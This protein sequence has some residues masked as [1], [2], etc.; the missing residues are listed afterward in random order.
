MTENVGSSPRAWGTHQFSSTTPTYFRF[1]PTCMG[2]SS[3][4]RGPFA[5]DTVHPHVH[6]ELCRRDSVREKGAG[7][8]PRAWGTLDNCRAPPC[9]RRFIPTC[10]G[11]SLMRSEA[12]I[13]P[14][15]H[16][17]VHG[18]L[19]SFLQMPYCSC[20]SSPRAWG[21]P[22]ASSYPLWR[23]RFIPTCMGNSCWPNF[24]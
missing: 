20:G 3:S 21:T 6:G 13:P 1:I 12:L 14:T 24:P 10:M 5:D 17:H 19:F 2:N 18:E 15:V 11:N 16:P 23:N 9:C 8:S 7:S 4:G 22:S